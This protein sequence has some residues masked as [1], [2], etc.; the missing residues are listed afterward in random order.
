MLN[1]INGFIYLFESVSDYETQYKIGFTRNKSTL[2]KRIQ[3]LQ[4]GNPNK[5]KIVNYFKTKWGRKV[6]TTLHYI[7]S[8]KKLEG[9]WFNLEL[10]DVTTFIDS[11]EKIE[12]NFDVLKEHQNPFL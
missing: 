8:Y 1:S 3:N 4:T 2:K 10:Y 12:K 6:E 9:E 11:C 5:I 7:Y